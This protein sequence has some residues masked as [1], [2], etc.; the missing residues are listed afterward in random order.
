MQCT[1]LWKQHAKNR[2]PWRCWEDKHRRSSKR[3]H[4]RVCVAKLTKLRYVVTK[5]CGLLTTFSWNRWR[6]RRLN[7]DFRIK[8]KCRA[9]NRFFGFSPGEGFTRFWW[10]YE[11]SRSGGLYG[12]GKQS[13]RWHNRRWPKRKSLFRLGSSLRARRHRVRP[14]LDKERYHIMAPSTYGC[15]HE[16]VLHW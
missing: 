2:L 9:K 1:G 6:V 12:T 7:Q 4:Q 5:V 10:S 13:D 14:N 15:H 16:Q 11:Q 3:R 8:K